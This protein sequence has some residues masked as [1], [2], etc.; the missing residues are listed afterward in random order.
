MNIQKR[1]ALLELVGDLND[2]D[3]VAAWVEIEQFF[4]GNDDLGSIWCNLD[5]PPEDM[6]QVSEFLHS[7][8]SRSDVHGLRILVTQ[9]DGG[10]DEWPFSDAIL[11]VTEASTTEVQG[12]FN[13]FPPNEVFIEES[14]KLLSD[15]AYSGRAAVR[16]W[17]N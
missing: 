9:F 1:D 8:R 14:E 17:W 16:L 6:S 12:W 2:F 4:D 10:E 3:N 5:E 13:Q 11:V 7:I 15:L